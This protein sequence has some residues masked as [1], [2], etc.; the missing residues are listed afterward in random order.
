[1]APNR[2]IASDNGLPLRFHLFYLKRKPCVTLLRVGNQRLS[3]AHY[4]ACAKRTPFNSQPPWS[5]S[6]GR[7]LNGTG[8]L[9]ATPALGVVVLDAH[10]IALRLNHHHQAAD[11]WG[12]PHASTC[13]QAAGATNRWTLPTDSRLRALRQVAS[14]RLQSPRREFFCPGPSSGLRCPVP[15]AATIGWCTGGCDGAEAAPGR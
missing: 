3:V 12:A 8:R 2:G 15:P 1:M 13:G 11:W 9:A 7:W 10:G 4:R 5:F 14:A 6:G